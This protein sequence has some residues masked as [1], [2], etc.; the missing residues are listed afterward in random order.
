M[1]KKSSQTPVCG[2]CQ[3]LCAY[4]PKCTIPFAAEQSP[5]GMYVNMGN[6]SLFCMSVY[7]SNRFTNMTNSVYS[8]DGIFG[9]NKG[10][11]IAVW[12]NVT[13]AAYVQYPVPYALQGQDGNTLN[14]Q[15]IY[16]NS[17]LNGNVSMMTVNPPVISTDTTVTM[18]GDTSDLFTKDAFP[19]FSASASAQDINGKVT[20][21]RFTTNGIIDIRVR[22]ANTTIK[23]ANVDTEVTYI[24]EVD[25]ITDPACP[26][27]LWTSTFKVIPLGRNIDNSGTA[28][29]IPPVYMT[30]VRNACREFSVGIVHG[31]SGSFDPGQSFPSSTHPSIEWK[32]MTMLGIKGQGCP[33]QPM[34]TVQSDLAKTLFK[35]IFS[36]QQ[37]IISEPSNSLTLSVNS[38]PLAIGEVTIPQREQIIY[39]SSLAMV[40]AWSDYIA[41][42]NSFI[43]GLGP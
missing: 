19:L 37:M 42:F 34:D 41:D 1:G 10:L 36:Y 27:S 23:I 17:L 13:N 8:I 14:G 40:D 30:F 28:P 25:D 26:V 21:Y 39:D 11:P 20:S 38:T 5:A 24:S 22:A 12:D 35:T 29:T 18:I 3:P 31:I 43:S 7:Y 32:P 4:T 33:I 15:I 2:T 16:I 6:G 9:V